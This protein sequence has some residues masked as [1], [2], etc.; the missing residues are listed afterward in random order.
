MKRS[1]PGTYHDGV[2]VRTPRVLPE[3]GVVR[4][5]SNRSKSPDSYLASPPY[6]GPICPKCGLEMRHRKAG[7]SYIGKP[8]AA[9]WG[10]VNFPHCRGSIS[11]AEVVPASATN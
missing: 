3:N 11:E 6:T 4:R 5:K 2:F 1:A 9:F 8:Y 10:C 7:V